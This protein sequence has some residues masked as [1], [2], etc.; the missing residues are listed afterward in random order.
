[1]LKAESK[2][3]KA[4]RKGGFGICAIK[5]IIIEEGNHWQSNMCN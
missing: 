4:K 2:K 1:M 3:L 5:K